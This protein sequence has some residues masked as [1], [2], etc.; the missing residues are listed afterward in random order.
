MAQVSSNR[1]V[2]DLAWPLTF[3]NKIACRKCRKYNQGCEVLEFGKGCRECV[4]AEHSCNL[5]RT[6]KDFDALSEDE[7]EDILQ[8]TKKRLRRLTK[9]E[10]AEAVRPR[11][12]ISFQ[13]DILCTYIYFNVTNHIANPNGSPS[14]NYTSLLDVI[15]AGVSVYFGRTMDKSS[16]DDHTAGTVVAGLTNAKE[17]HRSVLQRGRS[18]LPPQEQ[19]AALLEMQKLYEEQVRTSLMHV[20]TADRVAASTSI[21]T[22][23]SH[24]AHTSVQR[25]RSDVA[26]GMPGSVKAHIYHASSSAQAVDIALHSEDTVPLTMHDD[27]VSQGTAR[28]SSFPQEHLR[29]QDNVVSLIESFRSDIR[30]ERAAMDADTYS[31]PSAPGLNDGEVKDQAAFWTDIHTIVVDLRSDVRHAKDGR[32]QDLGRLQARCEEGT[33]VTSA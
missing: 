27:F 17:F 33:D 30:A 18:V 26:V 9:A 25:N 28:S 29:L 2:G 21:G 1:Q 23:G 31:I 5:K 12:I 13:A 22:D 32:L 8:W 15:S 10:Y 6:D 24:H 11:S 14:P 3:L 19:Q 20:N 16:N 7:I 4:K